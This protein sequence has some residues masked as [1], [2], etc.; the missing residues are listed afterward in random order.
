MY[1]TM[2]LNGYIAD[3]REKSPWP[4]EVWASYHRI[5]KQHKAIIIGRRTYELMDR[6]N[7]FR[8]IGNPFTIVLTKRKMKN[9]KKVVFVSSAKAAIRIAKDNGFNRVLISG[10]GGANSSLMKE[11]L[12]DEVYIDIV[13]VLF[14]KGIKLFKEEDFQKRLKFTG[15][16]YL[17][18]QVVQLRYRVIK[19]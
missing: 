11:N 3:E 6:I 14:G 9:K 16:K 5:S 12:V 18:K 8:K 13:P 1:L 17:S 15:L 2:S 4:K 7:E 19:R 10:G